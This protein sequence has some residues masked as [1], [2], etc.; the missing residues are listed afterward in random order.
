MVFGVVDEVSTKFVSMLKSI[1]TFDWQESSSDIKHWCSPTSSSIGC[2]GDL[3]E[4]CSLY[5]DLFFQDKH[6]S[7]WYQDV[8][9]WMDC[10]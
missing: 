5:V 8:D 3:S 10:W 7:C 4:A 6:C 1:V 9:I 2:V